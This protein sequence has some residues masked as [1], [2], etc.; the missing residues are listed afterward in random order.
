MNG[1][2]QVFKYR[3]LD[4]RPITAS[5]S[6]EELGPHELKAV[7]V[8][9]VVTGKCGVVIKISRNEH[10]SKSG[11][12]IDHDVKGPIVYEPGLNPSHSESPRHSGRP[13]IAFKPGICR[14]ASGIKVDVL[15]VEKV[16]ELIKAYPLVLLTI[17]LELIL[18]LFHVGEGEPSTRRECPDGCACGS[19]YVRGT[20]KCFGYDLSA[21]VYEIAELSG[22][23]TE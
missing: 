23:S 6:L 7:L 3:S 15:R 18:L 19:T 4:H 13:H 8:V 11:L 12:F 14:S 10:T 17:V 20:R 1:V 21:T 16:S 9:R 2:V 22:L 5:Q